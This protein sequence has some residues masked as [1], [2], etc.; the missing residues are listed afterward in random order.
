MSEKFIQTLV[1]IHIRRFSLQ[2]YLWQWE[3]EQTQVSTTQE[4]R[5]TQWLHTMN[6]VQQSE[7]IN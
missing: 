7:E 1:R 5:K 4:I 6:T 3:P 2:L